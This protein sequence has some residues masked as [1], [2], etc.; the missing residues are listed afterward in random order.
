VTKCPPSVTPSEQQ[1]FLQKINPLPH[2]QVFFSRYKYSNL[3]SF[4]NPSITLSLDLNTNIVLVCAIANIDYLLTYLQSQVRFVHTLKFNDHR[5]FTNYDVA[6]MKATFDNLNA[7]T[8][9]HCRTIIVTTEKDATRLDLHRD[10]ITNNQMPIF[11]L[12]VEVAFL[13]EE[14]EKFDNYIKEKL[15]TFKI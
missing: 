1:N 15:L 3:Y 7:D 2:Q 4:T 10:Y 5:L 8:P 6:Q 12:P 14:K 13:F 9:Q 11:I